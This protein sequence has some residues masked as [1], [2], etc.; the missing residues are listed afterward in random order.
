MSAIL[1]QHTWWKYVTSS[2]IYIAALTA[3]TFSFTGCGGGGDGAVDSTSTPV[4]T[5]EAPGAPTNFTVI[6]TPDAI[7]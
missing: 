1:K 6:R 4:P 3:I 7:L 2:T 5:V